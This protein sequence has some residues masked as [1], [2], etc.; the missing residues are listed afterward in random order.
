[1]KRLKNAYRGFTLALVYG[2]CV[3]LAGGT[4]AWADDQSGG[5]PGDWLSQFESARSIGIGGA[6]TAAA[7]EPL[8]VIWNPAGLS[9]MYQNT[10]HFETVRLFEGTSINGFSFAMPGRKFPSVG[11]TLLNLGAGDFVRTNDLNEPLGTFKE[12]DFAFL[13][14][15]AKNLGSQFTLGMN[16]KIAH[17]SIA[18]FKATGVGLDLGAIYELTPAVRLGASLLNL[19]GPTLVLRS[20]DEKF[21]AEFRGGISV[22][23]MDGR[24]LISAEINHRSGPGASFHA[25]SEF[26]IHR[27]MALRF[28][29]DDSSPGGGFSY[30]IS[31]EIR[32]DYGL[33][34]HELDVTHRFGVS[35][36]FG[37]FFASSEAHPPIFS[38][39]GDQSVTRFSLKAKT[40]ADIDIWRLEIVDKSDQV[41]R[42]FSGKGSPPVHVMW[43]GKSEMGL[44]LPDG[45][46]RYWLI[47]EDEEGG[48]IL[49]RTR[50]VEITTAGPQGIVPVIIESHSFQLESPGVE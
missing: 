40:K 29:F 27:S 13:L 35:Y 44:S 8:G 18:E 5:L 25:G 9:Q 16:L 6:F 17:Q 22:Y 28:G 34:D 19:G 14:S 45:L 47:V 21:P 36:S 48:E 37:G 3:A 10:V 4:A 11:A 20:I 49:G 43:D 32:V 46:Y 26:W 30:R 33:S 41:V 31:P 39:I 24:G 15:A 12:G 50:I 1:M 38:P 2:F 23:L 42:S 7:D